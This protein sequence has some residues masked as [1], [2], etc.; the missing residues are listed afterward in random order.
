MLR[1]SFPEA[2]L[3]NDRHTVLVLQPLLEG[4][5]RALDGQ[6]RVLRAWSDPVP[7]QRDAEAVVLAGEFA[8]DK[9]FL[10]GL[11]RL[12]H[13]ACFSVGYDGVDVA[14]ARGRGLVVTH[15]AAVNHEDVAD[16][17]TGLIIAQ[18]RAIVEGDRRLR[19]GGWRVDHKPM[20]RSLTGAHLGLVG[21][22]RI[23]EAVA[24]RALAMGLEVAWWGPRAKADAAHERHDS[25]LALAGWS[26][27]LVV[28]SIA[29]ETNR[30]LISA[31]VIEALGPQGLLVNVA[32]G[33]LVDEDALVAAL[34]DGRLGAAALDVFAEE[35]T[36]PARWAGL[37]NVVL[38]P[39]TAGATRESVARMLELLQLNL[40]AVLGGG[41]P[42][43][44]V[45]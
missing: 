8:L 34:S 19:E 38:T 13:L 4:V 25:L 18:R 3:L 5:A 43:T 1:F 2:T 39:H 23:G 9:A 24:R 22:G 33:Q 10:E 6:F 32:R 11:P 41:E 14:W 40:A 20:T 44:P 15:A 12:R 21:F 16:H 42:V 7:L 28:S 29:D 37:T 35:P 17:A 26:D 30:G 31:D 45:R 27:I 36:D